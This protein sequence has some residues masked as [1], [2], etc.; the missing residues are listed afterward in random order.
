MQKVYVVL[1]NEI[2]NETRQI[3]LQND[4]KTFLS[5]T[6]RDWNKDKFLKNCLSQKFHFN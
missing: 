3:Q 2:Y 4:A 1:T 6:Q 5:F